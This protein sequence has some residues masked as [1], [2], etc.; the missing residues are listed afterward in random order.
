MKDNII[1][2]SGQP[3]NH[4]GCLYHVTK[5]CEGCGRIGGKGDVHRSLTIKEVLNKA[6]KDK[7]KQ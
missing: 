3:C 5:P 4:K 1:W 2:K 7:E 6:R